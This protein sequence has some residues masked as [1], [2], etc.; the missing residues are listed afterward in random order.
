MQAAVLVRPSRTGAQ[1][2]TPSTASTPTPSKARTATQL[3][4]PAS[5][6]TAF[7][8]RLIAARLHKTDIMTMTGPDGMI[9]L[10]SGGWRTL[11]TLEGM[12]A[13]LKPFGLSVV[14]KNPGFIK[15]GW[16]VTDGKKF[17]LPYKDKMCV[18]LL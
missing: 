17:S 10:N 15:G 6:L 2:G 13:A 11:Q 5:P 1:Q 4:L 16:K 14:P 12:T 3:Q 7:R 9:S 8:L 18:A